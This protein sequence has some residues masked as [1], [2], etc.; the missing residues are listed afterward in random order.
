[1]SFRYEKYK[2]KSANDSFWTSYSDLFLGLSSIFLLLYVFSSLHMGTTGIKQQIEK[3]SLAMQ[4]EELKN[5]LKIYEGIRND[6]LK[7]EA[8]ESEIQEYRELMDKLT[9]L[10]E[11]ARDE[12]DRL[13]QAAI[14]NER[15]EKALNKYQQMVRNVLDANKLAKTKIVNRDEVITEQ[16]DEI[17]SQKLTMKQLERDISNKQKRLE[18]GEKL[19]QQTNRQL[20]KKA[21]ELK[22]AFERD[23]MTKQAYER[24]MGKLKADAEA[25]L[26]GLE[27]ENENYADQIADANQKLGALRGQLQSATQEL[28]DV[29]GALGRAKGELDETN[30]LLAKAK[31][32]TS[33]LKGRLSDTEGELAKARA[34]ADAR[35]KIARDI[36]E[37]F[38]RAGIKADVDMQTGDVVIDF[39]DAYFETNSAQMKREMRGILEKAMPIY[40]KSLLGD[41]KLARLIGAVEIIGFASPTY[42][43][44]FVDPNSSSSEDREAI[45]YNMDLSYRRARTIFNHVIDE[46]KFQFEYQGKLV[47]LLKVSGRSFLELFKNNR[48]L[49]SEEFCR[50]NDCRKAQRVIIRF[51]VNDKVK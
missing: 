41:P 9:L 8:P 10:Q 20:E 4:V 22:R 32:D 12:K 16:D 5:Q 28:G 24:Q 48:N 39:G 35:K 23:R 42:K 44:R 7:N 3:Q 21:A 18:E 11:E 46:N 2:E 45:R 36:K 1:M 51:N 29:Q 13:R 50:V 27:E 38:D 25:K 17:E 43:G 19:I 14:E 34:E 6:Y 26:R 49:A 37:G 47:P 30:R 40:A 33:R 31:Q 15:K